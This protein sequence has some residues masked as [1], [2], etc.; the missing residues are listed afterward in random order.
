MIFTQPEDLDEHKR[1]H[2][3][4]VSFIEHRNVRM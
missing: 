3:R 2:S 4:E 1:I